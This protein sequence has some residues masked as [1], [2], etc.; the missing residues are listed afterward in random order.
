MRKPR[1]SSALPG[2]PPPFVVGAII[3]AAWEAGCRIFAIPAY[4]FP[5][6]SAIAQAIVN[7][8]PGLMRALWSTL[9]VALIA[10]GLATA[11]GSALAF[12]FVQNKLIERSFFPYA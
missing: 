11:I 2:E 1:G 3:I 8:T 5:A 6:P 4:L 9:K 10:L 12:L 7:D